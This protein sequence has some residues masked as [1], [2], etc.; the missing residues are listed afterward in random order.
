M[1]RDTEIKVQRL[2]N[3]MREGSVFYCPEAAGVLTS[4]LR[5]SIR[6]LLAGKAEARSSITIRGCEKV[7]EA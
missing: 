2:K 4:S 3:S 6:E 1:R 7:F 5:M